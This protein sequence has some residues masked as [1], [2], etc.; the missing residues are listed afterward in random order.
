[1]PPIVAVIAPGMMG[2]AVAHRM[3]EKASKSARCWK[4]AAPKLWH[5]PRLLA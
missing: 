5:A 3:T 2:S 1:M 4:D